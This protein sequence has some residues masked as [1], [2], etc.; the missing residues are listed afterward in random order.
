VRRLAAAETARGA[1]AAEPAAEGTTPAENVEGIAAVE[2]TP[3]VGWLTLDTTPWATV[4][5]DGRVLGSTP[6]MRLELPE[7]PHELLLEN[8]ERGIR[9]TY[10]VT[11]RAGETTTRRL[12]L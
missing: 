12:G 6:L 9:R 2:P 3:A 4:S 8:P 10:V 7:G 5:V 11:V 1:S